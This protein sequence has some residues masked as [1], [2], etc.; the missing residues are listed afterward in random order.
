MTP[1]AAAALAM[2]VAAVATN[3]KR[4]TV[5]PS[6]PKADDAA[7]V[8]TIREAADRHGVPRQVALAFAYLESRLNPAAQ[9][10][11][12]WHEKRGGSLYQSLVRDA[13]KFEQNPARNDPEAW[14]SYG[15]FQLLAPYHVKPLEHPRVL[16]NP[17]VNADRGCA[18]IRRLLTRARGDVRS[19]RLAYV[20]CGFGGTLCAALVVDGY[21][22]K[23]AE[24]LERYASEGAS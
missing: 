21:T 6:K 23:L 4:S 9:G 11:L 8:R 1:F 18:E 15:L 2:M 19:A 17:A 24:A 3:R 7:I 13:A 22:K 14:H 12:E 16:L 20:G 10:D 5:Q